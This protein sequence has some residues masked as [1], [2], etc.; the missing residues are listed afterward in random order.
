MINKKKDDDY[1]VLFQGAKISK[2]EANVVG[3]SAIFGIVG[4]IISIFIPVAK[5]KFIDYLIII[6]FI[7]IGFFW[8]NRIFKKK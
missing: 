1:L 6:S 5:N 8:G 4:I 2:R 3:F 7:V